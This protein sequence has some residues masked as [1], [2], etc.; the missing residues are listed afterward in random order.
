MTHGDD[1]AAA[2]GGVIMSVI[3]AVTFGGIVEV[4]LFAMLGGFAGVFAKKTAEGIW[5][6]GVNFF[7]NRKK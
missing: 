4:I 2:M 5:N 6:L 7:K 1:I 3:T